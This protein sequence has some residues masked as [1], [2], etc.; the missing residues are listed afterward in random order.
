MAVQQLFWRMVVTVSAKYLQCTTIIVSIH[1]QT[2]VSCYII[3]ITK[4]LK[5]RTICTNTETKDYLYQRL[6][7]VVE[8]K[9]K[10]SVHKFPKVVFQLEK[11]YCTVQHINT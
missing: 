6:Y 7:T 9:K 2:V 1:I 11:F 4:R 5:Q 10:K 3:L 8:K